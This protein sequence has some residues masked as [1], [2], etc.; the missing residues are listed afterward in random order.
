M[1]PRIAAVAALALWAVWMFRYDVQVIPMLMPPD[2]TFQNAGQFIDKE[3]F[4]L[5]LDPTDPT[6]ANR[7]KSPSGE[8]LKPFNPVAPI[9]IWKWDRWTQTGRVEL[10]AGLDSLGNVTS[11]SALAP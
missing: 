7:V 11:K 3:G 10:V 2:A 5:V 9:A 1:K 4:L 6:A 8:D